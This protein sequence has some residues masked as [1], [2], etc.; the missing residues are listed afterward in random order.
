MKSQNIFQSNMNLRLKYFY[1]LYSTY[2][3]I[4]CFKYDIKKVFTCTLIKNNYALF[5]ERKRRGIESFY[6]LNFCKLNVIIFLYQKFIYT[7]LQNKEMSHASIFLLIVGFS[8]FFSYPQSNVVIVTNKIRGYGN[9][10]YLSCN[11]F[12]ITN[13]SCIIDAWLITED[14]VCT[15]NIKA[16]S[17]SFYQ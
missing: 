9:S 3:C 4:I 10:I 5:T 2:K 1:Y 17:D 11:C 7:Q 6:F 12:S 13:S 8:F 15:T 16:Y 14:S